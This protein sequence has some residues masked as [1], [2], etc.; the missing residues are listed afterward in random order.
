MLYGKWWWDSLFVITFKSLRI[1]HNRL[2]RDASMKGFLARTWEWLLRFDNVN[3]N[4]ATSG[5]FILPTNWRSLAVYLSLEPPGKDIDGQQVQFSLVRASTEDTAKICQYPDPG[6]IRT[7]ATRV[8]G[9][10]P[11][12]PGLNP[13]SLRWEKRLTPPHHA[14]QPFPGIS[15]APL[16]RLLLLS[17]ACDFEKQICATV[18]PDGT[19][20]SMAWN[21][22][23]LCKIRNLCCP[24]PLSLW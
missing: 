6:R 22:T 13:V 15:S 4:S 17:W 7:M 2:Q 11:S 10:V 19:A 12:W 8:G 16:W 20:P 1:L 5:K 24:K 18:L 3:P 23:A 21:T 14:H 9:G